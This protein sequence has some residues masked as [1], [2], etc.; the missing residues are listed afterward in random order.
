MKARDF[1]ALFEPESIYGVLFDPPYSPEQVKRSY[2]G[3][4]LEPGWDNTNAHF[5]P[6]KEIATLLEPG[7]ICIT[8]GW[9]TTGLGRKHKC[10]PIEYLIVN[11]GGSHH[12][13]LVT[14]ERKRG[15]KGPPPRKIKC[16]Q[17]TLFGGK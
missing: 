17:T 9:D 2:N 10:D 4:G 13:T 1:L 11:H 15:Y 8:C 14:V 5:Y 12:D 3:M 6:R 7:G 16:A